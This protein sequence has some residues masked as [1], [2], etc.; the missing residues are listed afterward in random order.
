MSRVGPYRLG[1]LLGAGGMGSVHRAEHVDLRVPV[2][3]KLLPR[4]TR[5]G[6]EGEVAALAALNHPGIV[7][8]VDC[9][10][11]DEAI[12]GWEQGTPWIAMERLGA[13]L[14]TAPPPPERVHA[15]L[16][17]VLRALAHAH[18]SGLLHLDIKPSN[19]LWRDDEA[20]LA[21]FGLARREPGSIT[22]VS[23]EFAAPEQLADG[24]TGP[25]TDL[26]AL[27][28]TVLSW[29][30]GGDGL[31]PWLL[32]AACPS[33]AD[34][35]ASAAEALAALPGSGAPEAIH[36]TAGDAGSP[37]RGLQPRRAQ[38]APTR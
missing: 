36:G 29:G 30:T 34:R 19:L 12:D 31:E 27:G 1:G 3:L 32:R 28:R 5:R 25:W 10:V 7:Q 9:G 26:Y 8:I 38:V 33:P 37:A 11:L 21:D 22:H 13:D 35:F 18:G 17:Q 15:T 23:A 6:F 2:A 24:T 16:R 4:S 20:V 14:A